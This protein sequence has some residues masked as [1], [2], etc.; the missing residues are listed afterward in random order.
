MFP[1]LFGPGISKSRS[2]LF[3]SRDPQDTIILNC[4]HVAQ[5]KVVKFNLAHTTQSLFI[6]ESQFNNCGKT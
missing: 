6:L 5:K 3:P 4:F 2:W 1:E